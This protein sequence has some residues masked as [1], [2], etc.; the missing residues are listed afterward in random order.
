ML[1]P[2]PYQPSFAPVLISYPLPAAGVGNF[3]VRSAILKELQVQI[4]ASIFCLVKFG[5]RSAILKDTG[6]P[7]VL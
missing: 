5:V 3:G 1:I 4:R 2:Y 7:R 6:K